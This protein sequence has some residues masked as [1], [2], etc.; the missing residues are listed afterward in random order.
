M[1]RQHRVIQNNG[2]ESFARLTGCRDGVLGK[3]VYQN[4]ILDR[5]PDVIDQ[6]PQD[7]GASG[8]TGQTQCDTAA[9]VESPAQRRSDQDLPADR[10]LSSFPLALIR[11]SNLQ[12]LASPIVGVVY[13]HQGGATHVGYRIA[14]G[15]VDACATGCHQGEILLLAR[16]ANL[17]CRI[18]DSAIESLSAL[19]AG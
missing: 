1:R 4:V 6:E 5:A 8:R 9:N 16:I 19:H 18:L 12:W 17:A 2:V 13:A 10:P 3:F 15:S 14:H 7:D 11:Q